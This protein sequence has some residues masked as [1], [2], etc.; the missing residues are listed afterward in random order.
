[1]RGLFRLLRLLFVGAAKAP[2]EVAKAFPAAIAETPA[3]IVQ[4]AA[5]TARVFREDNYRGGRYDQASVASFKAFEAKHG[6]EFREHVEKDIASKG[7]HTVKEI[8]I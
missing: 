3:A 2:V 8:K 5:P 1:M 7:E 6:K 4:A